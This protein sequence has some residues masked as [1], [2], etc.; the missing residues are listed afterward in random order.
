V[1]QQGD[2]I[3]GV[4]GG[5]SKTVAWLAL[6]QSVDQAQIIGR[7]RCGSSNCHSVGI[8]AATAN[9]QRAVESAFLDAHRQPGTVA[10]AC[11]ALAGADRPVEQDQ[12]RSWA[13][14]QQ[15]AVHLTI[16]NDALP[17]LYAASS[18]GIGIALVA[19]TGSLAIGR[20]AQGQVMRCGGWGSLMGDEGSG[21]QISLAGL[22]AAAR[23]AD[24]RGPPTPILPAMLQ[25]FQAGELS[26]LIPKIYAADVTRAA[27]AALAPLIFQAAQS[28]DAVATGIVQQ[29]ASEL[30][31]LVQTLARRL[32]LGDNSILLA[33]SGSVLLNQAALRDAIALRLADAGIGVRIVPVWEAVAGALTIACTHGLGGGN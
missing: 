2:L 25:H 22:R 7:G 10:S 12:F 16:V 33:V 30:S 18:C 29:A 27:I 8:A 23:A 11:L 20:S 1:N 32:Q 9:L 19:G 31:E 14:Q 28:G 17:V 24:G 4:D 26:E 6:R 5:G 13:E 15:L 21:Y 3:L